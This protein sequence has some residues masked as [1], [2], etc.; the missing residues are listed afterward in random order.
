M[1]TD[2]ST[3]GVKT[4]S[5]CCTSYAESELNER[6]CNSDCDSSLISICFKSSTVI[7][8]R[9]WEDEG[10]AGGAGGLAA[11]TLAIL[12]WEKRYIRSAR[13]LHLVVEEEVCE[14]E[15]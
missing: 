13:E 4:S 9:R 12:F 3:S 7:P 1:K 11:S 6:D 10:G 15:E 14:E 5:V 8:R 2:R